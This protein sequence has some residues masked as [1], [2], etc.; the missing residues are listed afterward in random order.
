MKRLTGWSDRANCAGCFLSIGNF[1]GVHRGHQA[2]LERLIHAA[3]ARSAPAVVLTFE[4]HPL[5]LLNPASNPPRLTTAEQKA[6]LLAAAGVD[7]VIEYPT[8]WPL[9]RLTPKEFFEQ[10]VLGELSARGLIEGPNFY[11]G[12]GRAGTVETLRDLCQA[13][14][15]SL[16]IVPPTLFG[17]E[18]VSSSQIRQ[19]LN[20]GDV[21]R[22]A[23]LLGRPY[24]IR[25][26]VSAGAARGRTLGF[27]T[28]NLEQ[29]GT[30]LPAQGV[31]AGRCLAAGVWRAAAVHL[32]PNPT[33]A[34]GQHKVE[35]HLLD[36]AGDLYGQSVDLEFRQRI[37]GLRSFAS[38]DELQ[39]QIKH[40]VA[41]VRQALE[42]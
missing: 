8:D 19:H 36:F 30:Q 7:V 4:P 10:I 1:D 11:F 33:F 20:A 13:A 40:D 9:L 15:R 3:R 16:E 31:Y 29:I 2:I 18:I 41:D 39:S 38:P 32:G 37:R 17:N 34:E 14:G 24:G 35:A 26:V 12:R 23:E 27:P 42:G 21:A 5:A 28:A 22:A 25:G 6:E